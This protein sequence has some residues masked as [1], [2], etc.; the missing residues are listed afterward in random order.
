MALATILPAQMGDIECPHIAERRGDAEAGIVHIEGGELGQQKA[1]QGTL[2]GIAGGAVVSRLA[3]VESDIAIAQDQLAKDR[4]ELV[5]GAPEVEMNPGL[6]EL[7]GI[8][9]GVGGDGELLQLK[10]RAGLCPAQP[11]LINAD[12]DLRIAEQRVDKALPVLIQQR[13][14]D[15]YQGDQHGQQYK[16]NP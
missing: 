14:S 13:A 10:G 6:A 4:L 15:P 8:A 2:L 11:N 5:E 16:Q 12:L 1:Q 7:D 3:E 9:P